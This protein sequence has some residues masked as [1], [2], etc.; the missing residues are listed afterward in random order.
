MGKY[1]ITIEMRT[2]PPT[3]LSGVPSSALAP[4]QDVTDKSFM[5][6]VAHYGP[7]DYFFTEFF[8]V[9]ESSRLDKKILSSIIDNITGRPVFAQL[10]GENLRDLKRTVEDLNPYPV[11]GVDFNLGCPA[12]K[13]YKKNVGGG[14]LRDP[15]ALDGILGLLR[16]KVEGLFTVKMRTGFED[17]RHFD[18]LLELIA[19]HEVDLLSLHARTVKDS[20]RSRVDYT[21]IKTAVDRLDCPVLANGNITSVRKARKVL[22]FTGCHGIMIGRSAIRNPWIFS[23]FRQHCKGDSPYQPTL[24]DVRAYVDKLH[25]STWAEGIPENAHIARLK[26][27]LNFIGLAVDE[28]GQFLY[29]IRRAHTEV[30]FFGICDQF[31]VNN[32]NAET[33]YSDEPHPGLIARP[34]CETSETVDLPLSCS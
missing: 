10:I 25:S 9:H 32:G 4:M 13:V 18:R 19:K 11:A 21:Y 15:E 1:P 14:L 6:V 20:Y 27:F 17:V 34:N 12:P 22:E 23:Q 31:L 7:P 8:R 33:F 28:A 5:D 29:Q 2:L 26:K 30:E 24:E 3:L 16:E